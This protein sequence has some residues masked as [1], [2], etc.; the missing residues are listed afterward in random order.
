M[1]GDKTDTRDDAAP[2]LTVVPLA[3][4]E[5]IVR[6]SKDLSSDGLGDFSCYSQ[7]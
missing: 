1:L 4:H 3:A 2:Q 7:Y 6:A 5:G